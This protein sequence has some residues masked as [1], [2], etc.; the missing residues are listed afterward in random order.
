MH[1]FMQDGAR[2][3]TARIVLEY[4]SEVFNERVISNRYPENFQRGFSWPA[5]SPDLNPCDFFLWGYLKDRVYSGNPQTLIELEAAITEQINLIPN[6]M[7]Q[8]TISSFP[9][10]LQMVVEK[11]GGHIEPFL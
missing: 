7:L 2:P 8:K 5:Y 11:N 9:R 1:F 10:R 3:H 4:L 6:E